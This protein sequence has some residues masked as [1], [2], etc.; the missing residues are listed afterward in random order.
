MLA[1]SSQPASPPIDVPEGCWVVNDGTEVRIGASS[2]SLGR[3][4]YFLFALLFWNGVVGVFATHFVS[5]TIRTLGGTPPGWM[6]RWSPGSGPMPASHLIGLWLFLTPF[7]LVGG[8]LVACF[9][10]CVAGRVEVRVRS[11]MGW[12]FV[13]IGQVG[14]T[15]R[16]D[17]RKV[18]QIL[19]KSSNRTDDSGKDLS[20][21]HLVIE[22]DR[23][24]RFGETLS[25]PRQMFMLRA[26]SDV[27]RL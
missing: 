25:P 2:A 15:R 20:I 9:A 5:E 6:P 21:Y 4:A 24:L 10:M 1:R 3:A 13:G 12:L 26:L 19:L 14:W 23:P 7:I 16:F 8:G 17:T 27:L 18:R 11:D 22:A